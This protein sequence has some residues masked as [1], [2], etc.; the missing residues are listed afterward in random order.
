[1][2][3]ADYKGMSINE[4]L[5]AAGVLQA[6]DVA[7]AERNRP[8]LEALLN[9]VDALGPGLVDQLLGEGEY[10]CWFCGEGMSRGGEYALSIGLSDLWGGNHGD[11]PTQTIYSHY[12]CAELRMKG[13]SM[14]LE[15][16]TL[17]P[18]TD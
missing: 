1:M 16:D 7:I 9:L 12:R 3:K 13:A 6:F 18:A 4:R 8:K 14:S 17:F 5:L 11:E 2:E 10:A 15:Q